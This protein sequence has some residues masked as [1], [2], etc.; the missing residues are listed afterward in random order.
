[1]SEEVNEQA[2]ERKE[3]KNFTGSISLFFQGLCGH[4]AESEAATTEEVEW[5]IQDGRLFGQDYAQLQVLNCLI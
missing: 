2:F 4:D 3:V 5:F 1:M